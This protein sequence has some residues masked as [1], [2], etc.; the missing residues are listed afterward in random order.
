MRV[1]CFG[2][3]LERAAVTSG[4]S[5]I[6]PQN[7]FFHGACYLASLLVLLG[8]HF[9]KYCTRSFEGLFQAQKLHI[10]YFITKAFAFKD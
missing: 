6:W 2:N 8:T 1:R 10:F 4:S 9:W 5:Q 7:L 3:L